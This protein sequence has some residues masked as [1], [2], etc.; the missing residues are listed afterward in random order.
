M[1]REPSGRDRA[2]TGT[3]VYVCALVACFSGVVA[4]WLL[5]VGV[6]VTVTTEAVTQTR[7]S[8]LLSAA[9]PLFFA[10]EVLFGAIRK[11]SQHLWIGAGGTAVSG[12]LLV[13]SAGPVLLVLGIAMLIALT[14]SLI[15]RST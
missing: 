15:P 1:T 13:F 12:G 2:A 11:R 3:L 10:V 7:R 6:E 8:L 4:L 9:I 14:F 5:I